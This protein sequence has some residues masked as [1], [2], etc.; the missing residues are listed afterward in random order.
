[1]IWE[2]DPRP[3]D[4]LHRSLD[5]LKAIHPGLPYHVEVMPEGTT[6]LD[7]A[8]MCDLS[9]FDETMYIDADTVVLERL[10][11]AFDRA[12]R[13]GIALCICECP[14][15]RRFPCC[16][17]DMVEY[18]TGLVWFD[19]RH[20]DTEKVFAMWKRLADTADS[21]LLFMSNGEKRLM[22]N[23]DQASFSLAVDHLDFNPFVLPLNF[24]F[25]PIWHK[26]WFGPIK[27]W[28]DYRPVSSDVLKWN[29]QQGEPGAIIDFAQATR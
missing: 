17:G 12:S 10:D 8:K 27:V 29:A 25:R 22:P 20:P 14:I 9:P 18:N 11:F 26:S 24:N 2:G 7:K 21:S 3:E 28:H 13:H 4:V 16:H 6:L 15:A 1:M 19:K 5:S 23:N